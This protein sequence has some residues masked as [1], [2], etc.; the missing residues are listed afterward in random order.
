MVNLI[1]P[2]LW[3][4][5]DVLICLRTGYMNAPFSRAEWWAWLLSG[6]AL[7]MLA[8]LAGWWDR[9]RS[10]REAEKRHGEVQEGQGALGAAILGQLRQLA[11]ATHTTGQPPATTVEV[12]VARLNELSQKVA[13]QD[14][15]IVDLKGQWRRITERQITRFA[16]AYPM[17]CG[18]D[19]SNTG[20]PVAITHRGADVE[21]EH[22]AQRLFRLF[23][24]CAI[25]TTLGEDNSFEALNSV[26]LT[27]FVR[28]STQLSKNERQV[29]GLLEAA[30]VDFKIEEAAVDPTVPQVVRM[31]VGQ[32]SL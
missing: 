13:R 28:D 4:L 31:R 11:T 12:A 5:F 32:H 2:A 29:V 27:L 10:D 21:A 6:I 24:S 9:R 22:Y 19:P 8:V 30:E 18:L 14:S 25:A 7:A 20:P 3:I 23:G 17:I 16:Q 1:V 15:E 26:G